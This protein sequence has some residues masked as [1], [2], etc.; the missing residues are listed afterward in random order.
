MSEIMFPKNRN[1][2]GL[3]GLLLVGLSTSACGDSAEV[4]ISRITGPRVLAVLSEPSSLAIGKQARLSVLVVDQF[5]P[6]QGIPG[7]AGP[8]DRPV[9]VIRWRAC[10]PWRFISDPVRDCVGSEAFSLT[11]T[12]SGQTDLFASE[13]EAAFP[14]PPD[15]MAPP[16][17][18]KFVLSLGI[19]L[20]IPILVEV[21]V[22]GQTLTTR[23]DIPVIGTD[24][25]RKTPKI[26][27][28]R[29]NGI[30]TNTI[31]RGVPTQIT[32]AIEPTS[33]DKLPDAT[34]APFFEEID[35]YFYSPVGSFSAFES[36]TPDPDAA[37]PETEA[38]EFTADQAGDTW[39]Y[40]VI[41]D[42]TGGVNA[43]WLPITVQ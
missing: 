36:A 41:T 43:E 14:A 7:A 5:G 4:P 28:V 16:E 3:L 38:I 30:A 39:L 22:D 21:D 1:V 29:F 19:K 26:A 20:T 34:E 9:D 17:A 13:L 24:E 18:W 42:Q 27:E 6:R 12:G 11:T 2:W 8:G 37:A 25:T 35:A 33:I 40:V 15:R 32:V 31:V 23:Y 10:A